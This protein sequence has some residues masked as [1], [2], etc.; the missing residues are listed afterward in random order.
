VLAGESVLSACAAPNQRHTVNSAEGQAI[1]F[2][3]IDGHWD[4]INPDDE[5]NFVNSRDFDLQL[6]ALLTAAMP[7]SGS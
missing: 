4:S 5:G 3:L 7:K 1:S 6:W 2:P